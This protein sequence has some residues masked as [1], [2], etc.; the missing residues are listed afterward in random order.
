MCRDLSQA[1]REA[2]AL[3]ELGLLHNRLSEA[4]LRV[5]SEGLAWPQCRVQKLRVHQPSLQEA[6]QCII[7]MLRQSPALTTLALGDCRLSESM[8]TYLCGALQD[9]R[10][11]L[12]ALSLTSVELSEPSLKE[13]QAVQT[14]K[15]GLVISHPALDGPSQPPEGFSSA[16]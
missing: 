14:A 5:L 9:P 1:L 7:S 12:Q 10:C 3:R 4:G 16:L 8:V 6:L 2:P 15:P 13:L 11:R